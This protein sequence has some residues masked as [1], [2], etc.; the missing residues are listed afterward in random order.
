MKDPSFRQSQTVLRIH[1]SKT[2]HED[3]LHWFDNSHMDPAIHQEQVKDLPEDSPFRAWAGGTELDYM[4]LLG[5]TRRLQNM[6]ELSDVEGGAVR[7]GRNRAS[8]KVKAKAAPNPN[9]S[10]G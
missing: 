10:A 6:E 8:A 5:T 9:P 1:R 2:Q 3:P 4:E 7:V